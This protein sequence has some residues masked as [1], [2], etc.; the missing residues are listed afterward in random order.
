[1]IYRS[2]NF[3][4][5]VL[6][7]TVL[8]LSGC[9]PGKSSAV[10]KDGNREEVHRIAVFP[11]FN[12]TSDQ[13]AARLLR[14][15]IQNALYFKGY[16]KIAA[17]FVDETLSGEQ[18]K[19]Q[20]AQDKAEYSRELGRQMQVDAVLYCDLQESRTHYYWLYSPLSVSAVFELR[21]ARSGQL[22]W[23]NSYST[24]KRTY[25][26][27][28]DSL[29]LKGAQVYEDAIQEL[30]DQAMQGIPDSSEVLG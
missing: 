11:V 21:S 15:K 23:R 2:S 18:A 12:E 29:R 4:F 17:Q 5:S 24:I 8:I 7:M 1:M 6:L 9:G 22:L 16:P 27:S 14:E 26:L 19:E 10:L 25:G 13:Q 3:I 20:E 30:V 28:K